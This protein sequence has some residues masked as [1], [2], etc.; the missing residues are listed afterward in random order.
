M[1]HGVKENSDSTPKQLIYQFPFKKDEI[2][3]AVLNQLKS[4][5]GDRVRMELELNSLEDAYL[6]IAKDEEFFLKQRKLGE[7]QGDIEMDEIGVNLDED[8]EGKQEHKEAV[9]R[10]QHIQA[11]PTFWKQTLA[12]AQ[13]RIYWFFTQPKQIGMVLVPVGYCFLVIA[14]FSVMFNAVFDD[15]IEEGESSTRERREIKEEMVKIFAWAYPCF[16][17]L[18]LTLTSS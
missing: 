7:R 17:V 10:Y 6:N 12:T 9:A 1:N 2:I 16:I 13:R 18:S 15:L 4:E 8:P 3:E 11:Y 14:F 5:V